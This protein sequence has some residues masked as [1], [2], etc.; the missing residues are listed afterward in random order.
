MIRVADYIFQ[1]LADG[2]VRQLFLVTGGG[3]MRL[4]DA[5]VRKERIRYVFNHHEQA[6]A[7]AKV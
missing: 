5:I 6:S 1:T 3:A 4:N 2:G 7:M